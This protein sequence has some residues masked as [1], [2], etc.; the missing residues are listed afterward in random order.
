M[1]F[2]IFTRDWS[3]K[4]MGAMLSQPDLEGVEHP[5]C[6]ASRS[7]YAKDENYHSFQL[8]LFEIELFGLYN[9]FDGE[10]LA[11]EWVTNHFRSKLFGNP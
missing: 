1:A 4:G 7:C 3:H 11:V 2:T 8:W 9:S 5:V 10:C 6:Y